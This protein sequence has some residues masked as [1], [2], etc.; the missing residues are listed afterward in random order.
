MIDWRTDRIGSA[1]RGENPTVLA[2]LTAGFA[3]IGDT[4]F[5]PGYCVLLTDDPL[6]D[7]L[8]DLPRARRLAFL[9]DMDLVGEAVATVCG[10]LFPGFRR[11]NYSVLGNHDAYLHAH[12][13]ARYD[14]EEP[15]FRSGPAFGYPAEVRDAPDAALG[16]RHDDLRA[17]LTSE[18][19]RLASR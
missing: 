9:A 8:L 15:S 14:W 10:R 7:K 17:E 2:R 18:I 4:Q 11:V 6:V 16:S 13:H 5:L 1:S 12:V 19:R 3:V